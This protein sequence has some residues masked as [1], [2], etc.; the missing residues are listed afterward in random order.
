[1][2][3]ILIKDVP[4]KGKRGDVLN[5]AEGYARNY[6][7]P[8]NLAIEASEG[9]MKELAERQQAN[10]IKEAKLKQEAQELAA[11]LAKLTVVVQTKAG[12][13]GRLF[14]SVNNKDICDAMLTQHQIRLDKKKVILKE[15]VKQ[16]GDYIAVAKLHPDVHAE[17]KVRVVEEQA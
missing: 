5:V 17:I 7:F 10:L 4:G 13:G 9:K 8:R 1:M 11:E 14:G 3:V 15:P 6:L 16:L 12:E 2:K